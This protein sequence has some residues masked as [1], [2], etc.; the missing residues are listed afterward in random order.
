MNQQLQST[1]VFVLAGGRGERLGPLT[2]QKP[3]PAVSFGGNHRII[4]F[5]LSNCVNSGLRR[6]Y[7]LTQHNPEPL[8]DYI[9]E[10]RTRLEFQFQW[11]DGDDLCC[12]PP[13]SGKRYRGT[14]DA[15]FQNLSLVRDLAEHVLIV[16]ADHVY[17]TD[18]ARLIAHHTASGADMTLAAVRKPVCEASGFGVLDTACDGTVTGFREK[19]SAATLPASGHVLVN[20]GIYVF[21]RSALLKLAARSCPAETDFGQHIVPALLRSALVAAYDFGAESKSYWRDVGT[22]DSYYEANMDLLGPDPLFV[23]DDP[24]GGLSFGNRIQTRGHSRI[25]LSAR[26][27]GSEIHRSVISE[28]TCVEPG[29]VV[30]NSIVLPGARIGRKARVQNAIVGEGAVV[31]SGARIGERLDADRGRFLVTP[32]GIVMVSDVL[33]KREDRTTAVESSRAASLAA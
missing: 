24:I 5:T 17:A 33:R 3:K 6:I 18:Y 14:A 11:K 7:I 22:I 20:M 15:V 4:D 27:D 29:A 12:L 21:R 1:S 8:H 10:S 28:T 9:Q 30:L 26:T 2:Q 16:S 13:T 32:K 19:P 25:S 31:N 23:P